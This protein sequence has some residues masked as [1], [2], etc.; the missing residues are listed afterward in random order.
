MIQVQ[1]PLFVCLISPPNLINLKMKIFH[2]KEK[3]Q[4]KNYLQLQCEINHKETQ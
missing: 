1:F 3:K 2:L 4:T